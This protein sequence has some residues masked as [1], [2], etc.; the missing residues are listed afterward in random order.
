[1]I[2]KKL[3]HFLIPALEETAT[4]PLANLWK[5]KVAME[6]G[7]IEEILPLKNRDFPITTSE[8]MYTIWEFNMTA[9]NRS[10]VVG[11]AGFHP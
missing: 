1:M 4:E 10:K 9:I 11:D 3:I 2:R 8:C 5:S 6:N 7:P